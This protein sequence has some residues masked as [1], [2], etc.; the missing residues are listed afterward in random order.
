MV[1]FIKTI[2]RINETKSAAFFN[3]LKG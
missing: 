1:V 3:V 2:V